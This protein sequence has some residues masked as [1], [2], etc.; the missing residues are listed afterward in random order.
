MI[1]MTKQ[2]APVNQLNVSNSNKSNFF[3]VFRPIYYCSRTFGFMPFT[4]VCDANGKIQRPAVRWFDILWFIFSIC[5][6]FL[7]AFIAFKNAEYDQ[8][9]T[10]VVILIVADNSILITGL[11]L[12]ALVIVMD[13]C[14][15]FK[16]I[17]IMKNI[18]TF[19]EEVSQS[20]LFIFILA[21]QWIQTT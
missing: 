13:M 1:K 12:S 15:R 7:S 3:N 10:E 14:N 19:D 18:N 21:T 17:D 11:I 2:S 6:Y 20:N 5:A 9:H 8:N 4:I 16:L